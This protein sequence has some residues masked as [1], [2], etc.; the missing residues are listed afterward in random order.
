MSA[1]RCARCAINY[2]GNATL[3]PVCDGDLEYFSYLSPDPDWQRQAADAISAG[4]TEILGVIDLGDS[5]IPL[6]EDGHLFIP[7]AQVY[8]AGY[9]YRLPEGQLLALLAFGNR[10]HYEVLGYH[11]EGRRYWVRVFDMQW[12]TDSEGNAYVPEEWLDAEA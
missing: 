1:R 2:P 6:L 3:C 7:F 8:Q 9:R 11:Q 10:L 12:P 5:V 4:E